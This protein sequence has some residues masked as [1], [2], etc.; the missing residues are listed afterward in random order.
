M[1]LLLLLLLL[2][3]QG[4]LPSRRKGRGLGAGGRQLPVGKQI[5]QVGWSVVAGD[6]PVNLDVS[7]PHHQ[8]ETGAEGGQHGVPTWSLS[9]SFGTGWREGSVGGKGHEKKVS[10]QDVIEFSVRPCFRKDG[11][12]DRGFPASL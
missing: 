7:S 12:N 4:P 2:L 10:Y 11:F 9:R 3:L 6:K 8:F 5:A 1:L